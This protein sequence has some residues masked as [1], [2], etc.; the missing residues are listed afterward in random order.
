MSGAI[1]VETTLTYS[2]FT[3]AARIT[4]PHFSVSSAMSLANSEPD[5]ASGVSPSS[6]MRRAIRASAS[7]SLI[8]WFSL[9]VISAGVLW[10]A[11]MPTKMLAS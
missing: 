7:A 6:A 2:A 9:P 4:L 5:S 3:L 11:T 10:G 1:L 8:S